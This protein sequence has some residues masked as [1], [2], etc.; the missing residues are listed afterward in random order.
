[1]QNQNL[2][3]LIIPFTTSEFIYLKF[4]KLFEKLKKMRIS[5]L[6][7]ITMGNEES[8]TIEGIKCEITPFWQ[9]ALSI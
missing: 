3:F 8:F 7:A 6:Y 4:K 2:A 5:K 9:Y 1:M